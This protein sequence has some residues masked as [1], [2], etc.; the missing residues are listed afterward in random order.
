MDRGKLK[1]HPGKC[2]P[3]MDNLRRRKPDSNTANERKME[4]SGH[5]VELEQDSYGSTRTHQEFYHG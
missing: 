4:Q 5:V 2:P 1:E 3:S